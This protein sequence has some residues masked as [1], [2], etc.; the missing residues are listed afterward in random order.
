MNR[1]Y[2]IEHT[3]GSSFI[4]IDRLLQF[5]VS[6]SVS[7]KFFGDFGGFNDITLAFTDGPERD[8]VLNTLKRLL[9]TKN[10][11]TLPPQS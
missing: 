4:N 3:S 2:E 6:G 8:R 7:I 9:Q 5:T 11:K 1:W 10:I